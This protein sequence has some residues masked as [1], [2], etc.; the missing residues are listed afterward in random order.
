MKFK[1]IYSIFSALYDGLV[2]ASV[3]A[4]GRTLLDNGTWGHDAGIAAEASARATAVSN[5][6]S[7]RIA[8]DTAINARIHAG[9]VTLSSGVATITDASILTTSVIV[10]TPTTLDAPTFPATVTA[11]IITAGSSF[12]TS[13]NAGDSRTFNYRILN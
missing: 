11:G 6:A 13:S 10:L 3:S 12:V 2:P 5:E 7:A 4:T 1:S 9:T 8:A